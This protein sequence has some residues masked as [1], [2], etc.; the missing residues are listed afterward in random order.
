MLFS[1]E[2]IHSCNKNTDVSYSVTQG[3]R[4]CN[5]LEKNTPEILY[6]AKNVILLSS[7]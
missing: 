3:Q 7:A 4:K 2:I 6:N 5:T 1:E